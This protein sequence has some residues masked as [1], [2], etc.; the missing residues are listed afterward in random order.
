MKSS[1]SF[2]VVTSVKDMGKS[3]RV[4]GQVSR[5]TVLTCLHKCMKNTIKTSCVKGIPDYG[6]KIF[7]TS[8]RHKELN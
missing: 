8:R 4:E 6:H 2:E 7:E 3:E 5:P 1:H